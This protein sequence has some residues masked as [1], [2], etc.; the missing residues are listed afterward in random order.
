MRKHCNWTNWPF[1]HYVVLV[2]IIDT[3]TFSI[4]KIQYARASE[5]K[6]WIFALPWGISAVRTISRHMMSRNKLLERS[7]M[8]PPRNCLTYRRRTNRGG[9]IPSPCMF[10]A[11]TDPPNLEGGRTV[12]AI[13]LSCLLNL[14]FRLWRRVL[15]LALFVTVF[16]DISWACALYSQL[17]FSYQ[18]V[19]RRV[20]RL[21]FS[22]FVKKYLCHVQKKRRCRRSY[23]VTGNERFQ[24]LTGRTYAL[25]SYTLFVS[26]VYW[27]CFW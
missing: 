20:R 11:M 7:W 27:G 13:S 14:A 12:R 17:F 19:G 25:A 5:L 26:R 16:V 3:D 4:P 1:G 22:S 10:P 24:R 21:H 8:F 18:C 2:D 15:F 9:P 6:C 23:I